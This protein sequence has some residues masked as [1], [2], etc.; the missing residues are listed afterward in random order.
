M[1]C[2]RKKLYTSYNKVQVKFFVK[3]QILI[4]DYKMHELKTV[5]IEQVEEVYYRIRNHSLYPT[6]NSFIAG[7]RYIKNQYYNVIYLSN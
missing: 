2:E 1:I 4:R 3:S 5:L 7:Y 6:K